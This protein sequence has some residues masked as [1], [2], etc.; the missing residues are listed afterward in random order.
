MNDNHNTAYR[1]AQIVM[2]GNFPTQRQTGQALHAYVEKQ[3]RR[4]LTKYPRGFIRAYVP[5]EFAPYSVDGCGLIAVAWH[6]N[7]VLRQSV[8][9]CRMAAGWREDFMDTGLPAS[10]SLLRWG[11]AQEEALH[12]AGE[13]PRQAPA[14]VR[15]GRYAAWR[16]EEELFSVVGGYKPMPSKV[17]KAWATKNIIPLGQPEEVAGES[18]RNLLHHPVWQHHQR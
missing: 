15:G 14:G 8:G 12:D 9:P 3:D 7:E 4:T 16:L 1:L 10:T 18:R 6:E 2:V 13:R 5:G 11:Y 17:R